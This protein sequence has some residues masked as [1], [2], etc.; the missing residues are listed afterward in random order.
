MASTLEHAELGTVQPATATP[1]VVKGIPVRAGPGIIGA[2]V[3]HLEPTPVSVPATLLDI[4]EQAV[5]NYQMAVFCF[6]FLDVVSTVLNIVAVYASGLKWNCWQLLFILL[7]V[8]PLCGLFGAQYL[9]RSLV[10]VFV[11]TCMVKAVIQVAYALYSF[12]FW[13][14]LFAFLQCW[15]TKIA[16]TFWW[17]LGNLTKERRRK[18]LEVK[19]YETQRVYW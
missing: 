7:L 3:N 11:A 5:L 4:D 6:A 2:R 16:A 14:I 10:L 17:V 9:K 13:T 15:I 12:Y 18:V 8:G 1:T 19:T